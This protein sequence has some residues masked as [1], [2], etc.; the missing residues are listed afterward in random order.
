[1]GGA[2]PG[3]LTVYIDA[4]VPRAVREALAARHPGV[5]Y[6]GGADAPAEDTLDEVWLPVAGKEDWVVIARDK[7]IRSRRGERRAFMDAGVRLFVL[8]GGG[9]FT[10]RQTLTLI[11]EHWEGVMKYAS[12]HAGPYY[13]SVTTAGITQLHPKPTG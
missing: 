1:M 4:S 9:N 3:R 2:T 7:K 13:C 6:A 5:L 8:T 11:E 10:I 12:T